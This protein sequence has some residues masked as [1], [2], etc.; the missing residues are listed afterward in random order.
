MTPKQFT[1]LVKEKG[2]IISKDDDGYWLDI[3][4]PKGLQCCISLDVNLP[5]GKNALEEISIK[6]NELE[7]DME[8]IFPIVIAV[9]AK[10]KETP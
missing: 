9:Q 6:L 3:Y 5:I 8:S 1:E 10:R 4:T 2:L 7:R